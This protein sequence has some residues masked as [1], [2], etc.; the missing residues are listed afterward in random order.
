MGAMALGQAFPT[1]EVIGSARG[2]AQNVYEIIDQK[3]SIDFSSKEGKKLDIVQGNIT[4]SNLHFT[5]PAR[6]DVKVYCLSI[7]C[8]VRI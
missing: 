6:P 2:A 1:L 3:S 7:Y 8:G 4:F 5:Y